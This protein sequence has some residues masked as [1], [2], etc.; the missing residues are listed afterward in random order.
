MTLCKPEKRCT[1]CKG[2]GRVPY[3]SDEYPPGTNACYCTDPALTYAT[4]KVVK[5][6]DGLSPADIERRWPGQSAVTEW[7][8]IPEISGKP[9]ETLTERQLIAGHAEQFPAV[10]AGRLFDKIE[11]LTKRIEALERTVRN[12]AKQPEGRVVI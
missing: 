9:V 3:E 11:A 8:P 7:L 2:T 10:V 6:L 1:Q 12:L 5:V 4:A